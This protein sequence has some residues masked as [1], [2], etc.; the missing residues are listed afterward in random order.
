MLKGLPFGAPTGTVAWSAVDFEMPVTEDQ[1][2]GSLNRWGLIL[3]ACVALVL[4]IGA[5][6]TATVT[7]GASLAATTAA[8]RL[9]H[10]GPA[11]FWWGTDSSPVEVP[12]RAPYGMP[13]LGGAYG[14]YIGM[15]GN[16]AY[17][18][19]CK[20]SSLAYSA[21]YA[22]QARIN[23]TEYSKGVGYSA[24]WFMGGPGVDPHYN[25]TTAEAARWGASQAA[26]ALR[27][28]ADGRGI[29]YPVVW[30]DIEL[31]GIKPAKDNGWNSVYTSPCSGKVR[32][33][34]VPATVD[35]ADF[36]GF[37]DYI[38]KH[39]HYKVGVY[40]SP[41]TWASIFGTGTASWIPATYEWTAE[42]QT[43]H[44]SY[45]PHGWCLKSGGCA[46]FFGGQT[47]KSK[48]ALMWQWSGGGEVGNGVGDLDQID[49]AKLR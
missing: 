1:H 32:E 28:I 26:R 41:A 38:T 9:D 22:A 47:Y 34:F 21:T 24:Y 35:R 19:G 7:A 8:M 43:A 3:E 2:G 16:W 10:D 33:A 42:P 27:D 31:P 23:Y 18:L 14:G 15:S 11:G 25:G 49:S 39:S 5:I 45:A 12:G 13:Y 40:S 30:A 44:L 48:Y 17:W 37:A 6:A 29:N 36:N 4:A 46:Q 20:D